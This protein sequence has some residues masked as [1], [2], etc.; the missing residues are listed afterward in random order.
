MIAE[1]ILRNLIIIDVNYDFSW[2]KVKGLS[3]RVSASRYAK[4][5]QQKAYNLFMNL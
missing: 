5:L 3:H 2:Q 4:P 1:I